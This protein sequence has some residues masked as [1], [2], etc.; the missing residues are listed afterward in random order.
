MSY[1][2]KSESIQKTVC[3][4]IVK[5]HLLILHYIAINGVVNTNGLPSQLVISGKVS[6]FQI[7][8][9]IIVSAIGFG[10]SHRVLMHHKND[11]YVNSL[12]KHAIMI[13]VNI[14]WI[15]GLHALI[16]VHDYGMTLQQNGNILCSHGNLNLFS[17]N[18]LRFTNTSWCT[19]KN[20][21]NKYVQLILFAVILDFMNQRDF[22]IL[23]IVYW[24]IFHGYYIWFSHCVIHGSFKLPSNWTHQN[25][26][27]TY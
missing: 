8:F 12:F 1:T 18:F 27:A 9:L 10:F 24:P 13:W 16:S 6:L 26:R 15:P 3:I 11:I 19:F 20:V 7:A 25:Y 4:Y 23:T 14:I 2:H 22:L 21:L 17:S 5:L